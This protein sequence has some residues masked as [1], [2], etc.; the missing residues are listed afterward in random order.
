MGIPKFLNLGTNTGF[1]ALMFLPLMSIYC[2]T[3]A[4]AQPIPS[5]STYESIKTKKLQWRIKGACKTNIDMDMVVDRW[6]VTPY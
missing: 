6:E 4:N 5:S 2:H 3:N 1:Y